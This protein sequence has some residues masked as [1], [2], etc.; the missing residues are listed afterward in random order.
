MPT[1]D[2]LLVLGR[3]RKT[4]YAK[5]RRPRGGRR[6]ERYSSTE[7]HSRGQLRRFANGYRQWLANLPDLE[8]GFITAS[9]DLACRIKISNAVRGRANPG[10]A[11]WGRK[12]WQDPQFRD[13]MANVMSVPCPKERRKKI[14]HGVA[15]YH[16]NF[17]N[18]TTPIERAM[19]KMLAEWGIED[20]APQ[21]RFGRY[22]VDIYDPQRNIAWEADGAYWHQDAAKQGKRDVALISQ[23]LTAVIHLTESDLQPWSG[24][25]LK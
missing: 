2:E 12:R 17:P 23:G 21:K 3:Q 11:I 9:I 18:K 16:Y 13:H 4:T 7:S 15:R 10:T 14:A 24:V 1:H 6:T 22:V 20:M 19:Y 8:A 25:R 5:R